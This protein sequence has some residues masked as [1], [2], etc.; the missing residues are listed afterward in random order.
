VVD[1]ISTWS[2]PSGIPSSACAGP[3]RLG[4]G[5]RHAGGAAVTYA[6]V[7]MTPN[8]NLTCRRCGTAVERRR[9]AFA[10]PAAICKSS[11]ASVRPCGCC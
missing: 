9:I 5:P 8:S 10:R 2:R 3:R 6:I 1:S 11:A 4:R 7:H